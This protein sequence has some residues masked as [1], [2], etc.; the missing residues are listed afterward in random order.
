MSNLLRPDFSAYVNA[1]RWKTDSKFGFSAFFH[2]NVSGSG[3]T[4]FTK[5]SPLWFQKFAALKFPTLGNV[6]SS[7]NQKSPLEHH[8]LNYYKITLLRIQCEK[9]SRSYL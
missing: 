3:K 4:I 1:V 7:F 2:Q 9:L 8:S 5:I 6:P